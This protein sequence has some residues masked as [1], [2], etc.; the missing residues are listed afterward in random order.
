MPILT[1]PHLQSLSVED[2]KRELS[3]L[4]DL[5]KQ[6]NL[7]AVVLQVRPAADAFYASTL[8]PWS[9]WLTGE[10][11]KSPEPIYDPLE[12]AVTECRKRGLDIHAWLNPYRAV[13]DT[14]NVTSPIHISKIHPDWFLT[15]GRTLFFDPGLKKQETG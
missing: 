8:E 15:Y 5:A 3:E 10:Q 13:S 4:L 9:Q 7:N 11:G 12:Y 14:A 1:G 2:Q 6:Y